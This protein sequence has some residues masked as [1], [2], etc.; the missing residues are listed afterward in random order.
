MKKIAYIFTSCI[1]LFLLLSCESTQIEKQSEV[2][3]SQQAGLEIPVKSEAE[4]FEE[5]LNGIKLS[6]VSAPSPIIAGNAFKKPYTIAVT[7]NEK[8]AASFP[9]IIKFPQSKE[10]GIPVFSEVSVKTDENGNVGF[11]PENTDFSCERYIAVAPDPKSTDSEVIAVAKKYEVKS[12]FK[13]KTKLRSNGIISLVDYNLSEK[14]LADTL[15][16]SLLLK[17]LMKKGFTSIG[18]FDIPRNILSTSDGIYKYVHGIVGNS[19]SFL[20]Y[21]T[22]KYATPIIQENGL[23]KCTLAGRISCMNL[24][25]GEILY[26]TEKTATA[27]E[28]VDWK[29]INSAREKLSEEL[30]QAINY[31]L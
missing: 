13:I 4:I 15:S 20:V 10:K 3:Q 30:G 28:S 6:V 1:T 12:D 14:P 24:K 27:I 19:V 7:I 18:N 21:G 2:L 8:P 26:T 29:A 5:S 11:N 17:D 25:T 22:V 16:S 31:N 23:Y 9:L